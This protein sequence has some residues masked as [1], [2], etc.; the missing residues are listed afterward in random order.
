M[1]C[2]A[3]SSKNINPFHFICFARAKITCSGH[4]F[5]CNCPIFQVD[6]DCDIYYDCIFTSVALGSISNYQSISISTIT[7]VV[8]G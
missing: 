8:Y 5:D 3:L 7:L 1:G 6:V 2:K 4:E